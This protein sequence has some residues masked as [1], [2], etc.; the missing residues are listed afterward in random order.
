MQGGQYKSISIV[1]LPAFLK[2]KKCYLSFIISIE[3]VTTSFKPAHTLSIHCRGAAMAT[4]HQRVPPEGFP[5]PAAV[6]A[7]TCGAEEDGLLPDSELTGEN[8]P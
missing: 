1:C 4:S 8:P 5:S 6:A 3:V 2:K 7:L